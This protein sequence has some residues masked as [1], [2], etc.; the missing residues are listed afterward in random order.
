MLGHCI[1]SSSRLESEPKKAESE[2]KRLIGALRVSLMHLIISD[3]WEM[4]VVPRSFVSV[5]TDRIN[6][7]LNFFNGEFDSGSER[8]LAAWIRHASRTRNY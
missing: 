5:Y 1:G 2:K 3:A 7:T 4:R 8:T 6:E